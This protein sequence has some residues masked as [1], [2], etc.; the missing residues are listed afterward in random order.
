MPPQQQDPDCQI[1]DADE[2]KINNETSNIT[3]NNN[4]KSISHDELLNLQANNLT[5]HPTT[6]LPLLNM[7]DMISV[8]LVVPLLNQYFLDAGVTN[9]SQR[10]LLSSLFSCAQII[11]GF[12][13]GG[14]SDVG[15][16]SRKHGLYLSFLGSSVSY[17]LIV[18]GGLRGLLLGRIIVGLVK[19]TG[20]ISTSMLSTYTTKDDRSIYMGRLTAST[21][22]AFIVGPSLGG[23]L[24]K[25]VDKKAPALLASILF[26]FNC[27]LAALF[28]P[29]EQVVPSNKLDESTIIHKKDDDANVMNDDDNNNDDNNNDHDS[30]TNMKTKLPSPSSQNKI[31]VLINNI[32]SCF[33][34]K[35]LG[36]V[37]LS[38]LLY[39]WVSRATSYA[40]MA[41]YYEE[42]FNI[43]PHQR[44]YIRSY[45]SIISF[46]FQTFFV[47]KT[48]SKL[49][50]EYNASC[51]ASFAITVATLLEFGASTTSSSGSDSNSSFYLFLII[52]CP[53]VAISNSI[54]RLSLRSLVTLVA[55]K[56]SIGSVLA[57]LDVLNNAASVSVPFYRTFLF[58]ILA[59]VDES[60]MSS[61]SS[62][63]TASM[64]GDPNPKMWLQSSVIHWT[65]TTLVLCVLL[66]KNNRHD[67]VHGTSFEKKNV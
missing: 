34:S 10:E 40:S 65:I 62:S 13:M 43:E 5:L 48:L 31:K 9:A 51:V 59:P 16:L 21:T 46:T 36:S 63:S 15:I 29:N 32:Q 35:Q 6:S 4:N 23:F 18:Y 24:Y 49:G 52:I 53:I 66:L 57:A 27:F 14:L 1:K 26:I 67:K 58:Q 3:N 44:G 22:L 47:R 50:N 2:V 56:S 28:L 55:P 37:I 12:V 45:T 11:G 20:T 7:L 39:N 64:I 33:S 42:M 38:L 25:N 17:A 61:S 8:A 30:N 54:L 41:S 60:S 19:Q